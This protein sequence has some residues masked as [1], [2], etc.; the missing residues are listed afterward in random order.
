MTARYRAA[1]IG[2]GDIGHAHVEGYH[3]NA[4]VEIVAVVDPI[5]VAREQ[6]KKEYGI[7]NAYPTV[8]E[9]FS[10]E[11]PDLASV[12]VW[13]PLHAP[14]TIA[15]A[16]AGVKGIICEK[17]MA[18]G[19]GQADAM[20]S[21]C[22]QA[23]AKLVISHQ[24]R[25]TP[26]YE[27]AR[28]LVSDGAIGEVRIAHGRG[29]AGLLNVG[30]HIIDS[31]RFIL[32]DP[33]ASW[34]MAAIERGTN[35][36]ERD[37]AIEDRCLVLVELATGGQLLVQSELHDRSG[38]R[39]IGMR[40]EGADGIVECSEGSTR[41]FN[42]GSGGWTDV[43]DLDRVDSIGGKANGDEVAELIRWLDGGPEPRTAAR[44]GRATTEIMMAAY[45]S[46]RR[47]RVI[48]LP[49]V[50]TGYP[51]DAWLAEGGIPPSEAEAYDI[52]DYLRRE[53]ADEVRYAQLRAE[54]HGHREIMF[55]LDAERR[56]QPDAQY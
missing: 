48:A 31:M 35:R 22:D 27:A 26:G 12:C 36:F 18:L 5:E 55:R 38:R 13:H 49:L 19:M 42:A 33:A 52:R 25:Y 41:L 24:R 51:M 30:T 7:P 23:G 45:E 29:T 46:A 56:G 17:P 11:V 3:L 14:L 9:M 50:E 2:C 10:T 28:R 44:I 37:T 8:E 34:V 47:N 20:I 54:G 53:G 4:D 6:Y 40:F 39:G 43:V 15:A 16:Q 32:G 1:I 21:A